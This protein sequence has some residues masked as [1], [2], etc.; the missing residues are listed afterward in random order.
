[1]RFTIYLALLFVQATA[2]GQTT[3]EES[4][5]L[6]EVRQLRQDLQAATAII[7]RV[8]IVMYRLQA[9]ASQLDRATQRLEQVRTGCTGR[10]WQKKM[11][12]TQIEQTEARRRNAQNSA[13]RN[14]AEEQIPMLRASAEEL[15]SQEQ[16]CQTEEAEAQTQFQAEQAKMNDLQDQLD[17]LDKVLASVDRK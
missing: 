1:M 6:M 14:A 9:E 12:S 7:Q 3:S 4:K 10:Q 2:F 15:A 16:Q 11:I 8:Q 17:K 13:D 5:M